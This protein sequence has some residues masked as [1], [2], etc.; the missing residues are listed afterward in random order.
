[1][2][3]FLTII[4]LVFLLCFTFSCQQGEEVAEEV[5]VEPLTDEDVA[6]NKAVTEAFEQALTSKD[7]AALAALYTEDA[8]LMPP[9]QPIVQGRESILAFSKSFPTVTEYESTVVEIYGYGDIAIVRGKGLMTIALEGA[10]ELIK[11]TIKYIEIRR[12]QDDGSW[13]IAIDI[14]NSDLPLPE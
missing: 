7:W 6:A 13:L 9:N 2:K 5:G 11:E 4:P 1:M 10:Q 14:W 12:K 3:K 8:I